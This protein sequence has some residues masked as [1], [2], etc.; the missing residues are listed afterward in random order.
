MKKK[1]SQNASLKLYSP[2]KELIPYIKPY[3]RSLL[4]TFIALC[5]AAFSILA[6]GPS[7]RF[8]I[9]SGFQTE[10]LEFLNQAIL[11]LIALSLVLAF[12]AYVRLSST[13]WLAEQIVTDLRKDFFAHLLKLDA[14]FFDNARLG[15]IITRLSDDCTLLKTLLSASGAIVIRGFIQFMGA[16][17]LMFFTSLKLTFFSLLIIPVA[18]FPI[19]LLGGRLKRKTL[20]VQNAQG[21]LIAFSEERLSGITTIQ[22]FTQ[23]E[24]VIHQFTTLSTANLK[25]SQKNLRMRALLISLVIGCVFIALSIILSLGGYSVLS[26][27]LSPGTF[28]SF[29]FYALIAA[30]SLNEIAEVL[31]DFQKAAGAMTRLLEILR[32]PSRLNDVPSNSAPKKQLQG[33]L[34]LKNVSFAYPTRPQVQALENISF[35]IKKG[36]KVAIVGLSGAGKSTLFKLLLRF[37]DPQAGSI[38]ID[39]HAATTLNL[40]GLRQTFSLVAQETTIFHDTLYQNIVFA[41]P[42]ATYQE[43]MQAAEA[44]YVNEFAHSLPQ[45]FNTIVGDQGKQLSGGQRQRVAIAR[46]LL[47]NAPILLLDEATNALDPQS[48][49]L[50]QQAISHLVKDRT[51]LVIAHHLTTIQNCGRV[52]VMEKG[53]LVQEGTHQVLIKE[54]GLYSKLYAKKFRDEES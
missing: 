16:L 12:S 27:N 50:I 23:E 37:Y 54:E 25:T 43:V 1:D 48:E 10:N 26:K 22:A 19:G 45:G 52:L 3:S 5:G 41:R 49:A 44:A 31:G 29:L 20:E 38:F 42:E 51:T 28:L 32:T 46:A 13:S 36:E 17:I 53:K 4:K 2:L 9:D 40:E 24:A 8:L 15:D 11:I 14:H 47:K 35:D 39:G 30:G 33:H 21:K 18:F 7:L 6:I 34:S